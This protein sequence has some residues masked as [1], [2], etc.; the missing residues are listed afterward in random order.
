MNCCM[1]LPLPPT[2]PSEEFETDTW[3]A[4]AEVLPGEKA[5]K[6]YLEIMNYPPEPEFFVSVNKQRKH[7]AWKIIKQGEG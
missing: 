2:K 4:F 3:Y 1:G 6:R 7:S 5:T